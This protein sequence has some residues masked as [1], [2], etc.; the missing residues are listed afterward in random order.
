MTMVAED[1][2]E[3]GLTHYHAHRFALAD[4]VFARAVAK[5]DTPAWVR[6]RR[7]RIAERSGRPEDALDELKHYYAAGGS[8]P[9]ASML[10][11]ACQDR[12]RRDRA[13]RGAMERA[14]SL[15]ER[16]PASLLAVPGVSPR[17]QEDAL[18]RLRAAV[19]ARPASPELRCLL[20]EQL[21]EANEPEEAEMHALSGLAIRALPRASAL[22]GRAALAVGRGAEAACRLTAAVDRRT[23]FPDFLL[24]LALAHFEI[25]DLLSAQR[26]ATQSLA[27]NPAH[28][29]AYRMLALILYRS[30]DEARAN[31]ALRRGM[32]R[33]REPHDAS[34]AVA[35]AFADCGNPDDAAVLEAA[36]E[37]HPEYPDLRAAREKIR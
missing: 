11:A 5:P 29:A 16:N 17:G 14:L 4:E 10:E 28:G 36:I 9:F 37:R 33:G 6:F 23:R 1:E 31:L 2:L 24:W 15:V 19:S 22:A 32:A 3:L 7:A 35:C 26:A 21:L 30:G 12:V 27:G 34:P 8:S 18:R 25:G 13:R 20:A